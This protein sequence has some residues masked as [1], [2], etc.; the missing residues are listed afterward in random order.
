MSTD[1]AAVNFSEIIFQA[2][3]T[4]IQVSDKPTLFI[5]PLQIKVE[6]GK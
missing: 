5:L 4:K 3:Q 2:S 6:N 1:A